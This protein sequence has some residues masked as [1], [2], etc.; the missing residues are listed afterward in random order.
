MKIQVTQEHIDKGE[1]CESGYCPIAL[2]M[3][4][5]GFQNPCVSANQVDWHS[6]ENEWE[7]R[8][9]YLPHEVQVFI[10]NFDDDKSR[11]RPFAFDIPEL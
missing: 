4:D 8:W 9:A 11:V 10:L 1:Q 5:A 3:K 6:P 7:V 2:A